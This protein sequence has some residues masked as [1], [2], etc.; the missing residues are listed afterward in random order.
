MGRFCLSPAGCSDVHRGSSN[1]CRVLVA[2]PR[3]FHFHCPLQRGH[4][5]VLH[6]TCLPSFLLVSHEQHNVQPHHLRED[7]RQVRKMDKTRKEH[8]EPA[9]TFNFL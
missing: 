2:L 5:V 4:Q 7:E 8:V 3:L 1:L 9:L 6:A